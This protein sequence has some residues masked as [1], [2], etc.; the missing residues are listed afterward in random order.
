MDERGLKNVL[1]AVFESMLFAIAYHDPEHLPLVEDVFVP[2]I[3]FVISK[4]DHD[5]CMAQDICEKP[6]RSSRNSL[7]NTRN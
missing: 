3:K 6:S 7:S 1:F 5:G 4:R 2:A